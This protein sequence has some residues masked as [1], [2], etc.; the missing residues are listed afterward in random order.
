MAINETE[1][2]VFIDDLNVDKRQRNQDKEMEYSSLAK[3][4]TDLSPIEHAVYLL[5]AE[6]PTNKQQLKAAIQV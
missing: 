1:S 4:V 5:K 3:S 2:L 6:R